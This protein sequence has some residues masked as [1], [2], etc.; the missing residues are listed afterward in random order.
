[1]THVSD[2]KLIRTDTTLD[3]SQKA[4]KG[5]PSTGPGSPFYTKAALPSPLC[6]VDVGLPRPAE[7]RA[8]NPTSEANRRKAPFIMGPP[9]SSVDLGNTADFGPCPSSYKDSLKEATPV[10]NLSS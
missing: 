4:E 3:L 10:S 5:M 2:I 7:L 6:G 1:M 9:P 8:R